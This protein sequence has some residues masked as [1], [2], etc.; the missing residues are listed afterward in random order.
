[1]SK[2]TLY[3]TYRPKQT[4]KY[5]INSAKPLVTYFSCSYNEMLRTIIVKFSVYTV[6][7]DQLNYS[8]SWSFIY[9]SSLAAEPSLS[10]FVRFST[11]LGLP[12]RTFM[13]S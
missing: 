10:I 6:L 13:Y 9:K 8:V 7:Q 4:F 11:D 1:M 2:L 12:D 5:A 3:L